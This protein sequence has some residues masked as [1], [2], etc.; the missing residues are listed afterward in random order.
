MKPANGQESTFSLQF[1]CP[2]NLRQH[3][4]W[5]GWAEEGLRPPA[6]G[7]FNG[8]GRQRLQ[9]VTCF[10][11]TQWYCLLQWDPKLGKHLKKCRNLLFDFLAK[12]RRLVSLPVCMVNLNWGKRLLS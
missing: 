1:L 2:P 10:S 8:G 12:V 11:Y 6:A 5:T 9:A 7:G 4:V 3:D